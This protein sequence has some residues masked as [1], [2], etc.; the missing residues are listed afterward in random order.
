MEPVP[1]SDV[2]WNVSQ[3]CLDHR[4]RQLCAKVVA[5]SDSDLGSSISELKAALREHNERLRKLAIAQLGRL[6][7]S[8]HR[9]QTNQQQYDSR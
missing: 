9:T 6:W 3:H 1:D 7:S 5:S 2:F 4:I 8:N